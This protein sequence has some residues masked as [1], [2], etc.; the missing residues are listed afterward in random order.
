MNCLEF[1]R[2][3]NAAPRHLPAPA[4]QHAEDCP[5]CARRMVKQ[6][7]FEAN[8][9]ATLQVPAPHGLE[10]RILLATRFSEKRRMALFA[11]AASVL[12]AVSITLAPTIFKS[13]SKPDMAELDMAIEHVLAEP[14]HLAETV[15]VSPVQLNDLLARVG[16]RS[17]NALSVT[18]ANACDLPNGK[19]GHIVLNTAYGRVTLMLMPNGASGI[20]K[21]RQMKGVIAEMYAAQ[22][23][24][25]SLVAESDA[26]LVAAR[27]MLA[28]HLHWV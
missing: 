4:R 25:Y 9:A 22:H 16:A 28:S 21:R 20:V 10:D 26:A 27:Q 15:A 18:Y 17:D 1:Q 6:L 23:G 8:L 7:N 11:V 19:G 3:L 2:A 24:N 12:L 5:D 14:Q 13:P